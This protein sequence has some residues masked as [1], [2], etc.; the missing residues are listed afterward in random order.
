MIFLK[1]LPLFFPFFPLKLSINSFRCA[2]G[3]L[4]LTTYFAGDLVESSVCD[5]LDYYSVPQSPPPLNYS[6]F[7]VSRLDK[8]LM[9]ELVHVSVIALCRLLW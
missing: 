2:L 8:I 1:S 6:K 7:P 4:L 9:N 3:S 5:R